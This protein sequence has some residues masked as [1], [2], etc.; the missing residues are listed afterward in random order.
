MWSSQAKVTERLGGL[1]QEKRNSSA[2]AMELRLSYIN[3]SNCLLKLG[4]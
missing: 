3:L 4:F 1:M 2:L